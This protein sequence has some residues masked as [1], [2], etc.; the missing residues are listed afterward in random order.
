MINHRNTL[1]RFADK[2]LFTIAGYERL[3]RNWRLKA[4]RDLDPTW[5]GKA[6]VLETCAKDLQFMYQRLTN[7]LP[8]EDLAEIQ[9]LF[10]ART[11]KNLEG[12]A[13]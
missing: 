4:D 1:I 5:T 13:A 7:N 2:T 10:L 8:A 12:L 3:A 6:E 11:D 9:R